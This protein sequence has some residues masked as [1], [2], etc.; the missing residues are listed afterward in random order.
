MSRKPV[1]LIST[2]MLRSAVRCMVRS[3]MKQRQEQ[4]EFHNSIRADKSL[5]EFDTGP[6]LVNKQ[7]FSLDLDKLVV[8]TFTGKEIDD[9]Y[10]YRDTV[11]FLGVIFDRK[12]GT[13]EMQFRMYQEG[14]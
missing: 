1:P 8:H 9:C 13:Y 2:S 7:K 4:Q 11:D 14:K 5:V 10:P 6:N 12:F 3:E